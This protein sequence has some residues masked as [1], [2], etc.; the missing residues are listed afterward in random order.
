MGTTGNN[1]DVF[2]IAG[3]FLLIN[4]LCGK[5]YLDYQ[6]NWDKQ[7]YFFHLAGAKLP[8]NLI[9]FELVLNMVLKS[10]CITSYLTTFGE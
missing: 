1:L 3:T 7:G 10:N 4:F 9:F 2:N 8:L 5:H 6:D